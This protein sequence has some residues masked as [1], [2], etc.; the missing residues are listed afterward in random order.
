MALKQ[1]YYQYRNIK[2]KHYKFHTIDCGESGTFAEAKAECKQ[3]GISFRIID[4]QFY[5]EVKK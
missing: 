5:K 3:E 1:S 2:G 4:G